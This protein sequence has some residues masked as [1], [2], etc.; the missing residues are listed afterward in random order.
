MYKHP[1]RGSEVPVLAPYLIGVVTAPLAARVLKPL[2]RGIV[3]S[4]VSLGLELKKAAAEVGEEFQDIAAEVSV[5]K[6]A[7]TK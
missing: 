4:T 1:W 2:L 7:M 3:K 5:D 6:V